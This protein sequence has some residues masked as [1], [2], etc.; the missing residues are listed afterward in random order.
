MKE[1][2]VTDIGEF[3]CIRHILKD[4]IYRPESVKLGAG[5]DGAVY[6]TPPGY[7][8]V[9]STDTMVEGIHFTKETMSFSDVGYRICA[10][11]FSDMAAMGAEPVAFVLSLALPKDL[12]LEDLEN[13]YHGIRE[14]CRKYSVNLLGGD[15]TASLGGVILTGTVV[16]IVP[17]D[18][19]VKRSG[20]QVGDVVFVTETVG[21]SAAGLA[22]ILHQCDTDFPGLTKRHRRP[23]AQIQLGKMLREAGVTSL[24]DVSDGLSQEL[25]EIAAA[26]KVIINLDKDKIPLSEETIRL[27]KRLGTDPLNWAFIGG[28]DYELAGT[29]SRKNWEKIKGSLPVTEI[30]IVCDKGSGQVFIKSKNETVLMIPKGYDHFRT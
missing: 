7:D 26:S 28:E 9:I 16:G 29:M 15:M 8:Q 21:D 11:N 13:C 3:G 19:A 5:D 30:G 20:A 17:S 6:V 1:K 4:F 27:G 22:A 10:V 25:N 12:P 24:N 14:C 23:E 2:T 18:R